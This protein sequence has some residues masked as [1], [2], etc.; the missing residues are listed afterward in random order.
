MKSPV[1]LHY[2]RDEDA[3]AASFLVVVPDA[4]LAGI[5]EGHPLRALTT[6]FNTGGKPSTRLFALA[7]AVQQAECDGI[8]YPGLIE[9]TRRAF[10]RLF[11][12][13]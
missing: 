5:N 10:N 12:R 6:R 9:T 7:R 13:K 11:R 3:K 4:A 2:L 8:A 1:S